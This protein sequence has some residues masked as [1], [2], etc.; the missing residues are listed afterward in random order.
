MHGEFRLSTA[1]NCAGIERQ[2]P[3]GDVLFAPDNL[4]NEVHGAA[5]LYDRIS[6]QRTPFVLLC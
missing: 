4:I 5:V 6:V 2:A 1:L 3:P